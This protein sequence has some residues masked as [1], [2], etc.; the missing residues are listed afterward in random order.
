MGLQQ[1]SLVFGGA[2]KLRQMGPICNANL[3]SGI[4]RLIDQLQQPGISFIRANQFDTSVRR[5]CR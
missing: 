1:T 3:D 5:L 4:V 2:A